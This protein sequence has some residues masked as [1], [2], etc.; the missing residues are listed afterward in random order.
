MSASK[1]CL[2]YCVLIPGL[3]LAS[4][5]SVLA[6]TSE[7]PRQGYSSSYQPPVFEQDNRVEQVAS[8]ASEVQRIIREHAREKKIPGIAYGIVVDDSLVVKGATGIINRE[9]ST[10][11]T[12]QSDFRIASM[13]KS[14][15]AMAIMKLR[16]EGK[17][18]LADPAED[19]IPEMANLEYLTRDAPVIRIE[20][21]LTM[22]AGFPEDNPWGDRQLDEPDRMLM[23]LM[24]EGVSFSNVPA[25]RYEYSNT[26]YALLGAIISRVSGVPYQEYIRENILLPLGM[27]HTYWEL[28]KVP[29]EQLAIGYR[30]EDE[31][32]SREPMLHD[33]AFGAMGGLITTIEDFSRYVSYHLD[34]W[35]PRNEPDNG[36]VSRGS[37][38][39]MQTPQFSRLYPDA[40]D[41]NDEPCP[42]M[43]GYGYG[44]GIYQDCH[45]RTVVS[46]GGA[47]PG[48]GSNYYFFPEYGVGIMAF[49]NLTYTSPLP[50]GKLVKM[51]FEEIDLPTR[52]LPVSDILKERQEQ[53]IQ[54]I[55]EWNPDLE[56][57][58][59]AENF[60]L[61][62]SR[63]HRRADV[64]AVLDQA[65]AIEGPGEL[66]P[67][68]QL[69]GSFDLPAEEGTVSIYFTLTPEQNPKVQDL[70]VSFQPAEDSN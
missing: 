24:S 66:E 67:E 63:E 38:R 61:D 35:P 70:E 48:F 20:N 56:Q 47:L 52:Q 37:R 4:T 64:Q 39:K 9:D 33:G 31:R 69:R 32:W 51:L 16:D 43:A 27:T 11:A 57:Q 29:A 22:T 54:L 34:A 62:K 2:T 44:L 58:I 23:N 46:H 13:T 5:L 17:L 45:D 55:Q 50:L 12:P 26:G 14:F 6:Q 59:L 68:N 65:G 40:Q 28:D 21:L 53:I 49:G 1:H 7:G 19:Y 41:Y 10:S 25:F 30:W 8:L 18:S 36:P 42:S 3:L 60:Y 15:T